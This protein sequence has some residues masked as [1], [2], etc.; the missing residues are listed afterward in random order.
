M[1]FSTSNSTYVSSL[2]VVPKLSSSRSKEIWFKVCVAHR[3]LYHTK[4]VDISENKTVKELKWAISD[5]LNLNMNSTD[6]FLT[7]FDQGKQI[8]TPISEESLYIPIRNLS[9]VPYSILN[10][11][12][13]EDMKAK[14]PHRSTIESSKLTLRLCQRPLLRSSPLDLTVYS[15]T[16]LAELKAKAREQVTNQS[17]DRLSLWTNDVWTTFET[18]LDD[19][20]LAELGFKNDSFISFQS[21]DDL[22]P[23]VCGLTN[24]GSTC[25]M[26]SALQ[27]LSNIPYLTREILS[28]DVKMDAPIIGAYV[29][30]VK[31]LWSGENTVIT[32]S[33]LLQNVCQSL[34]RFTRYRQ[35]D[36]QEFMNHFLHLMHEELTTLISDVFY[37]QLRSTVKCLEKDH[38]PEINLETITFL[39][40]PIDDDINQHNLLY[41]RSNGERQFVSVRGKLKMVRDLIQSFIDQHEPKLTPK[42][43]KAVGINGNYTIEEYSS[44]ERLISINKHYI[45]L[46]ETPE[47]NVEEKYIKF[48][49]RAGKTCKQFRPPIFLVCPSYDCRYSHLSEQIDRIHNHLRSISTTSD[50]TYRIF[51]N[52]TYYG[53]HDLNEAKANNEPILFMDRIFIEIDPNWVQ[54]YKQLFSFDRP[55][56][57]VSLTNLL[58]DFFREE[59][60]T[61]DY[62]CSECSQLTKAKQK[63]DLSFP[64][65]RVLII[66]LKRFTYDLNSNEKID[67]YIDF[68]IRNLDLDTYVAQDDQRDGN[69]TRLYDLVAVS[70]HSGNLAC[71]HYTTYAKNYRNK[72]WY[73]FNDDMTRQIPD[74]KDIVTKNAY[75]LIYAQQSPS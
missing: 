46:I 68:P 26:N 69:V 5:T 47:K 35:H 9:L 42:Q 20:S 56:S 6:F 4:Y 21:K 39:P 19:V 11:E 51:W 15:T 27:C 52:S 60:L 25:F 3:D 32:P 37:G 72:L 66:Q 40:L 38:R 41:L 67:T 13:Y 1:S 61:G 45:T 12:M 36:A 65:P 22:I 33:S 74:E 16:T 73:S 57:D 10:V 17:T 29:E 49:F 28:S 24:L 30:L 62:Y 54:E 75:I 2:S 44:S 64:L 58:A 8:W 71:G 43:I 55:S 18:K 59:P 53:T 23:G 7:I 48:E 31:T 70:N 63:T 50:L 14:K 34:P